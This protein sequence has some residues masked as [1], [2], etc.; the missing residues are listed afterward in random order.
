MISNC[1]K[2]V[3]YRMSV[4]MTIQAS[5]TNCKSISLAFTFL[6]FMHDRYYKNP[7]FLKR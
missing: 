4:M 6:P 3:G 7:Y 1:G 5:N 2:G